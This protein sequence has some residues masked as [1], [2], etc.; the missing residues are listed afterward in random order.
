MRFY[1]L[2]SKAAEF[3]GWLQR[4]GLPYPSRLHMLEFPLDP[5]VVGGGSYILKHERKN[6]LNLEFYGSSKTFGAVPKPVVEMF[7][8]MLL[9]RV[10]DLY[11]FRKSAEKITRLRMKINTDYSDIRNPKYWGGWLK[12]EESSINESWERW[13]N[14]MKAYELKKQ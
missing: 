7:G 1:A 12:K 2:P 3:H 14:K 9:N 6:E 4:L 8:Y 11:T 13:L 10:D 5:R